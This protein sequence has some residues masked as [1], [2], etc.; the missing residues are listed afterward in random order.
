MIPGN[1][2]QEGWIFLCFS[3]QSDWSS[4]N[5]VVSGMMRYEPCHERH[6]RIANQNLRHVVGS[7][8]CYISIWRNWHV[9]TAQLLTRRERATKRYI[10]KHLFQQRPSRSM[11]RL[12]ISVDL[13]K[14]SAW[15]GGDMKYDA[16][17]GERMK[18]HKVWGKMLEMCLWVVDCHSRWQGPWV[19]RASW[20]F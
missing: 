19:C 12:A 2:G 20:D 13:R 9:G 14:C 18:D 10:L 11:A 4:F 1:K 17:L 16:P 3:I 6:W 5:V 7:I 15:K 8:P